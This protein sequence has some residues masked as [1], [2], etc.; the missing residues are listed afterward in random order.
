MPD[1]NSSQKRSAAMIV[2]AQS[3]TK[4]GDVLTNP[5]TVLTWLL[6]SL[7]VSGAILSMLVPIRESGSMLPQL[8]ISGWVKQVRTRKWVYVA[9]TIAQA[10]SIAAM[11]IAALTLPATAAGLVVLLALTCFSIARAFSSISAKDVLGRTI[12]KGFRGRVGGVSNTASGIISAAAAVALILFRPDGD[13]QLLAALILAASLLWVI[14]A[15]FYA[16]VDEPIPDDSPTSS[17]SS[18]KKNGILTRLQLVK[19]DPRFRTFIVARSLLLGSALAS[20]L[21]VLLGQQHGASLGSL[22]GFVVASGLATASSSFFWGRLADRSGRLAMAWGGFFAAGIGV[23][24]CLLALWSP[25]WLQAPIIWPAIFL[26]FNIGYAGT[27]LGRKTWIVDA[28]EGDHRTD[29]VSASNTL[30][31]VII[32]I[33]GAINAPLLAWNPLLSLGIYSTFCLI[34]GLAALRLDSHH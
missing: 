26:L 13:A 10:L 20:P 12:P 29:Y 27:R 32:I 16:A 4:L 21:L 30:I 17:T 3:A 8:F 25:D 24:S 28:T 15:G 31:A 9:G 14:G 5:K 34:G 18:T 23:I 11:G 22:I 2:I 7:G 19:N 33:I 6:S 1:L